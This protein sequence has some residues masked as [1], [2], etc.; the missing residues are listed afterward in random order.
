M[1]LSSKSST[2]NPA[3]FIYVVDGK[4]ITGLA[5]G[6]QSTITWNADRF[7]DA[8]GNDGEHA[9][10][11]TNDRSAILSLELMQTSDSNEVLSDLFNEDA[12]SGN[13]LF[14]VSLKDQRGNTQFS[15]TGCYIK[16]WPDIIYSDS[17]QVRVWNIYCPRME[18]VLSGNVAQ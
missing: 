14:V 9:R 3:D 18:G 5:R 16:K 12:N 10:I 15:S 1:A 17:I 13:R 4:T 6:T 7:N 2:F 8:I 11:M